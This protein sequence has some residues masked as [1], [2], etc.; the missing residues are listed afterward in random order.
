MPLVKVE[1]LKGKSQEYK[2]AILDGI[3]SALVEAFEILDGDRMQRLYELDEDCFERSTNKTEN[4]TLIELTVFKG[5]SFEAKKKLYSA[6][7]RNLAKSPGI[8]G[9]D[10]FIVI[11]EPP[12]ENWGVKGGL[13]ASEVNLGF[14]I[15]V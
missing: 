14:K 11:N 13:P 3:H 15:D 2:K 4:I 5:R 10:I 12:L 8:D 1:I 7:V 9:K 6:I